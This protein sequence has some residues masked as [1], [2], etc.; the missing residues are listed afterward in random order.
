MGAATRL[1]LDGI[2][3][4]RAPAAACEASR[5]VARNGGRTRSRCLGWYGIGRIGLGP[6]PSLMRARESGVSFRLPAVI[7]LVLLHGSLGCRVPLSG[8]G[9]SEV[10][11]SG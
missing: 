7:G 10:V 1:V 6:V 3:A 4:A 11:L 5:V 8:R 9:G 2:G